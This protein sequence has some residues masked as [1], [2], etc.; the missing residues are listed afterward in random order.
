MNMLYLSR[1]VFACFDNEQPPLPPPPASE[2][3]P[4]KRLTQSEVNR[5]MAEEERT[6]PGTASAGREDAGGNVGVQ[7]PDRPR[8][9]ANGPRMRRIAGGPRT[10]EEQATHEKKQ[11][12]DSY[13]KQLV[14]KTKDA[15][16]WQKRYESDED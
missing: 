10:K 11:L 2:P 12:E 5:I 13:K 15:E 6:V 14:E 16:T 9:R 7:E 1:P 8:A 4:E 3:G